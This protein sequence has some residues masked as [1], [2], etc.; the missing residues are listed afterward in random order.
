MNRERIAFSA[1]V[2]SVGYDD[3]T[4]VL[5]V[6]FHNGGVYQYLGVPRSVYTLLLAAPSKGRFLHE[7]VKGNY[8]YRKVQERVA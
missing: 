2:W 5:E 3:V 6:E 1:N 7:C 8:N 4:E